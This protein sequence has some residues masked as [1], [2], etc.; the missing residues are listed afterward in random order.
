MG[1]SQHSAL[2]ESEIGM[3]VLKRIVVIVAA[4][5]AVAASLFIAQAPAQA[6]GYGC[7]GNLVENKSLSK[8]GVHWGNIYL[9]WDGTNNCAVFVKNSSN[10]PGQRAMT[11]EIESGNWV[12]GQWRRIDLK[13]DP[14]NYYT[15]AG[16]VSLY[17]ANRCVRAAA[18]MDVPG[19]ASGKEYLGK[20]TDHCG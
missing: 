20:T 13:Q 6:G 5:G 4:L 8:Y 7:S 9:Y 16:P 10:A 17:G 2:D 18:W 15:Y 3:S 12:S 14:G 1:L 19:Y 11:V